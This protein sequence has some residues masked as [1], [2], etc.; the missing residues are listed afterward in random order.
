MCKRSANPSSLP[1]A[2]RPDDRWRME[3]GGRG[4]TKSPSSSVQGCFAREFNRRA[5]KV[6]LS[7]WVCPRVPGVGAGK[8]A[9]TRC[10]QFVP[11]L[12]VAMRSPP[13]VASS[14]LT[15]RTGPSSSCARSWDASTSSSG[16]RGRRATFASTERAVAVL[17]TR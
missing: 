3:T 2:G 7:D 8:Q 15:A 9:P 1:A 5:R 4:S 10:D 17:A 12:S 11:G 13:L 14:V 6:P 16:R